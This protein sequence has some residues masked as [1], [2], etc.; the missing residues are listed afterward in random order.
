MNGTLWERFWAK[1]D[2][3]AGPEGCWLWTAG[4]YGPM[5]YGRIITEEKPEYAHRFSWTLC[6]GPIPQGLFVLHHCDVPA[7]VNPA[8]LF[9]G[10]K[11][12]NSIDMA[13]KGRTGRSAPD[14]NWEELDVDNGRLDYP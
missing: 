7:C 10:T 8:H 5:G 11:K 1:V 4:K 3:T 12:D 9:L 14:D 13:C 2:M 6:L